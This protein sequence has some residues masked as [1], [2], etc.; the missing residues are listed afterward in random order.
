MLPRRHC[1]QSTLKNKKRKAHRCMVEPTTCLYASVVRPSEDARNQCAHQVSSAN[2]SFRRSTLQREDR[3][4]R[5]WPRASRSGLGRR[6][7]SETSVFALWTLHAKLLKAMRPI[8]ISSIQYFSTH[9][10]VGVPHATP[11][12]SISN[13]PHP[14]AFDPLDRLGERR[15]R[16][17]CHIRDVDPSPRPNQMNSS[18]TSRRVHL[19]M[20]GPYRHHESTHSP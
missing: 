16:C 20:G 1:P 12:N 5:P 19:N 15:H 18:E 3:A 11:S 14:L 8:L 4:N 9:N 6:R 17:F 10:F 2:L 13:S 7:T